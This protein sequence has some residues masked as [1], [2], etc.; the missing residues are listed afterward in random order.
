MVIRLNDQMVQDIEK[1]LL[2]DDQCLTGITF[3]PEIDPMEVRF[4]FREE[5]DDGSHSAPAYETFI[6]Q[7]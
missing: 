7:Q 4:H 6:Q 1:T 3:H 5:F 2:G